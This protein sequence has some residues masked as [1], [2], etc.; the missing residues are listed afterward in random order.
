MAL[1]SEKMNEDLKL[2]NDAVDKVA[3]VLPEGTQAQFLERAGVYL[4]KLAN[5]VDM[6][7]AFEVKAPQAKAVLDPVVEEARRVAAVETREAEAAQR[8]AERA[9][10][11]ERRA[12]AAPNAPGGTPS[13][14]DTKRSIAREAE[15]LAAT[16]AREAAAAQEA[17]RALTANAATPL[18]AS[19][20]VDAKLETLRREQAEALRKLTTDRANVAE[21]E[22]EPEQ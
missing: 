3:A 5:R 1:T 6:Q 12:E 18:A 11:S 13:E 17:Q 4:E 9:V 10:A 8:V 7:R 20:A 2:L 19:L 15:R 14:I 16:E 21:A 22:S